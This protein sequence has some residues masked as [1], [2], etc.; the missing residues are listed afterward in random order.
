M[1]GH[2]QLFECIKLDFGSGTPL[3]VP[4]RP[5]GGAALLDSPVR[6]AAEVF[7]DGKR[8]GA[9]WA[10]PFALNLAG[11][12]HPGRNR[13]E[14]CVTNTAINLLAGRSP[15]DYRSLNEHFGVRFLALP[16]A[17]LQPL[18][19]GLLGPVTLQTAP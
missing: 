15:P 17:D 10:P 7:V 16:T 9:V 14:I 6:E 8:A 18:P 2:D 5:R 19:S 3:P 1:N 13:L 12:L 11:F 4:A